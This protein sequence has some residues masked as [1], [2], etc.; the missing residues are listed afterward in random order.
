MENSH[1]EETGME[2]P[3]PPPMAQVILSPLF[4]FF[5]AF[6]SFLFL[7]FV[8]WSFLPSSPSSHF[9]VVKC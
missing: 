6:F 7:L 8:G 1:E 3:Y 9:V 2:T 4:S 5:L